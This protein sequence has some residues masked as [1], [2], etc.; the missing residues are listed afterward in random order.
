MDRKH[1]L[2]ALIEKYYEGVR[3]TLRLLAASETTWERIRDRDPQLTYATLLRILAYAGHTTTDYYILLH[4]DHK[5]FRKT[6]RQQVHQQIL[7][8]LRIGTID[9]IHE[10]EPTTRRTK[11]ILVGVFGALFCLLLTISIYGMFTLPA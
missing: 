5:N 4:A 8:G 1:Q 3:P 10:I 9:V 7:N 11:Y 2:F 6:P